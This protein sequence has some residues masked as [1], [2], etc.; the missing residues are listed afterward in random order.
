MWWTRRSNKDSVSVINSA[1]KEAGKSA[2]QKSGE[3]VAEQLGTYIAGLM[4]SAAVSLIV[5]TIAGTGIG[6][7]IEVLLKG[8]NK[9]EQ[10]LNS[11]IS[12]PYVTGTREIH[13]AL[14]SSPRTEEELRFRDD[15]LRAG[16]QKL[17]S[18]LTFAIDCND[19]D[20][21]LFILFIISLSEASL[22]GGLESA[23]RRL[24][25]MGLLLGPQIEATK[26]KLSTLPVPE[27]VISGEQAM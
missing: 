11:L 16:I 25:A 9:S 13:H 1:A 24:D 7:L 6:K 22:P 19:E 27:P 5:G 23:V 4:M 17:Q 21:Q 14:A 3:K 10:L 15:Q 12:E 26:H 20:Q 2:V 8:V 18:A